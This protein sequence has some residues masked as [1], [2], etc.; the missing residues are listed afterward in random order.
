MFCSQLEQV[1]ANIE[2]FGAMEVCTFIACFYSESR[3]ALRE[4]IV[5]AFLDVDL[6]S[7]TKGRAA[8]DLAPSRGKWHDIH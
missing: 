5:L 7:S 6:A 2:Q 4:P 8:E 1:K 3:S